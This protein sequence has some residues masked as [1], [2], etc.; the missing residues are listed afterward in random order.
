MAE[1]TFSYRDT[2]TADVDPRLAGGWLTIDLDAIAF[3]YRLMA[4][5]A[6]PAE[7][8]GV[9]KANAYGLGVEQVAPALWA[10]GCRRFFVALPHEGVSLRAI[11]PEADIFVLSGPISPEAAPAFD[12]ANL[13]PVLNSPT[14][15]STWEGFGWDGEVPRPCAVHLDT[16]MNR[17]GL[18]PAQALAFA[19]ENQ[20]TRALTPL[21]LMSHLACADEPDHP[22]NAE[23]KRAFMAV[24]SAF[25]GIMASLANSAGIVLGGDYLCDLVRPG[26]ALYGAWPV[27]TLE[28]PLRTVV[29]AEARI[30]Q[31]RSARAGESVSYGATTRLERDT[32]IA[33]AS[34][35]YADGHHRAQSGAG[36]PLRKDGADG[37]TGFVDGRRVPI[38]GRVTMDLTMFDVTELGPDALGPGDHIELFG[39]NL[40]IEEAAAAAGTIPYELLTSLGRRYN[41]RYV[42]AQAG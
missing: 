32:L 39:P 3:N 25:P 38:L 34:A 36:V 29:T 13:F 19:Q 9:V 12:E 20:L 41:R 5:L 42:G 30:L 21:V 11:L 14:D 27:E 35:G 6:A 33:V 40:P 4:E 18:S 7:A 8:A 31:V 2:A 1:S 10:A 24:G 16:G 26:I 37:G 17:L 28:S 23:Q 22:L 15:L